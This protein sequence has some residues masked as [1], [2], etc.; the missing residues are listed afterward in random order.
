MPLVTARGRPEVL[1][2]PGPVMLSPGVKTALAQCEVGHRDSRF[3]RVVARLRQN[4]AT[5]LGATADHSV[6]FVTGP[7]TSG[8]EATFATLFPQ[9]RAV[10]VPVNGAFGLRLVE[11]LETHGIPCVPVHFGFGQPYAL[12]RIDA[13]IVEGSRAGVAALA[14]T[15]HETSAGIVN[16]VAEVCAVARR[17]GL[18]T[19][20]DATSS[21]GAEALDVA[22]DGVDACVTTSGKCLHGAPGVA[23]VCV[24]REWLGER[25]GSRPR[26]YSLDLRRYHDQLET[27]SQTPFTPAVPQFMALDRAVEELLQRGGVAA[28]RRE[29][30]RRRDFLAAAMGELGLSSLSLP[31]GT[32]ASS[33]LTVRVP[34][35]LGFDALYRSMQER[36]YVIYG[37][38]APLAPDYFQLSVMGELSD[39]DLSGFVES[40]RTVLART[41]AALQA[42][43]A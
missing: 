13:A 9:E 5:V 34:E 38:K 7:A 12:E 35:A 33:I 14:M 27:N 11:I 43:S 32:E 28:R 1:L 8:I 18:R 39:A 24:S 19:F 17:H 25:C 41:A 37:A 2:C 10:L 26:T 4:C 29:Y 40:L 3:A 31:R 20:V 6:M 15:H 42:A 21:A 36:G 22:R 30:R 23:L 16:P